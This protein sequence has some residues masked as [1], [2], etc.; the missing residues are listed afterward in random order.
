MLLLF[1]ILSIASVAKASFFDMGIP[2]HAFIIASTSGNLYSASRDA[3]TYGALW[4]KYNF[5]LHYYLDVTVQEK[6]SIETNLHK[7]GLNYTYGNIENIQ[8]DISNCSTCNKIVSISSHGYISGST[9]YIT[10]KGKRYTSHDVTSWFQNN[11]QGKTLILV[12]TCHSGSMIKLS[13]G[14]YT[15]Q[16]NTAKVCSISACSDN[17]LDMDDISTNFGYGGG[18]TS[19]IADLIGETAIADINIS[20]I[21]TSCCKRL[22][23]LNQHPK[24]CWW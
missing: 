8:Q 18:L 19:A 4:S 7:R 10:L 13:H 22:I 11:D 1:Y 17:E 21:Y 15:A 12:D 3:I 24:L 16:A 14:E 2:N 20:D 9:N 23:C 6:I 5:T